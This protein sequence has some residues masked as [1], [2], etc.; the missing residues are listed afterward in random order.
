MTG[1]GGTG[2]NNGA[3]TGNS[4][5]GTSSPGGSA[6]SGGGGAPGGGTGSDVGG[7]APVDTGGNK[8]KQKDN[9]GC[10]LQ[11]AGSSPNAAYLAA[12]LALGAV[13]RRRRRAS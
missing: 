8:K 12:A 11:P 10:S 9:S 4:V 3:G 1:T 2:T 7:D 5:A 13:V 6:P